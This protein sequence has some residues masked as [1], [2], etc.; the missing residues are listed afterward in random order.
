MNLSGA[1]TAVGAS[2]ALQLGPG[3]TATY[4]TAVDNLETFSGLV[5]LQRSLDGGL[6]WQTLTSFDGRTSA[7]TEATGATSGTIVNETGQKAHY[8]FQ[9]TVATEDEELDY[10]LADVV[11]GERVIKTA[12]GVTVATINEDGSIT[13]T[14]IAN[15]TALVA[16][17]LPT[18]IGALP[19]A[20]PVAVGALWL[21]SG[22]LT[23]GNGP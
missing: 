10:T 13:I 12:A 15:L 9:C 6:S 17:I 19:T 18:V 8:R 21:N 1:L 5:L 11:D 23:V 14:S 7:L 16:A 4:T 3:Q 2:K 22:V 20:E